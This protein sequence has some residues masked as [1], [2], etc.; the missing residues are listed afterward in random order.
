MS[1]ANKIDSTS[2]KGTS[3]IAQVKQLKRVEG[4]VRGIA[5]MIEDQRYC[6]DILNQLKA[7]RSSISSI[8]RKIVNEHLNHCVHD[9]I[10]TKNKRKSDEVMSEIRD[11]LKSAG[12]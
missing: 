12:L 11:L 9:A 7:V 6:I 3:H 2:K 1:A 5:Q 8:E 10:A 4:Q